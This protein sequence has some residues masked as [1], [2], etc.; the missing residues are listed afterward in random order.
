VDA[1]RRTTVTTAESLRPTAPS[2]RWM[3]SVAARA[4]F[5]WSPW[6]RIRASLRGGA[7]V[8]LTRYAYKIDAAVAAPSPH[9]VRPRLELELA[10][11]IW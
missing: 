5:S 10:A 8:V 9:W 3:V 11:D 6:S 4:G 1:V 2:T 7:D